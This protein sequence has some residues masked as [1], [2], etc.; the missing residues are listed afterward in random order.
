MAQEPRSID[1]IFIAH[2]QFTIDKF[3]ALYIVSP[4]NELQKL[5]SNHKIAFRY[6][7]SRLGNFSSI[8]VSNPLA[9]ICFYEDFQTIIF[10]DRTLS[11]LTEIDLG[12]WGFNNVTAT[13]SSGNNQI[14]IYDASH[15]QLIQIAKDRTTPTRTFPINL[16]TDE[17]FLI[18]K[19]LVNKENLYCLT[20]N[21]NIYKLSLIGE[22]L[23]KILGGEQYIDF[24]FSGNRLLVQDKHGNIFHHIN[25]LDLKQLSFSLPQNGTWCFSNGTTLIGNGDAIWSVQ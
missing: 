25:S 3:D 16:Q 18:T 4:D 9:I 1:S 21:G 22:S 15:M 24:Q 11:P 19:M 5:N 12:D 2:T 13:C 14:W 8:D 10:L 17:P 20:A 7:N 6:S 23:Q